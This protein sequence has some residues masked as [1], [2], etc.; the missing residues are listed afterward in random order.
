VGSPRAA[1][2]VLKKKVHLLLVEDDVNVRNATRLLLKSEGYVVTVASSLA[3]ALER[4]R[5]MPRLDLL[6]TDYHLPNG[7]TGMQVI[8]SLRKIRDY[9]VGA[10]LITGDTSLAVHDLSVVPYVR[11]ASKPIKAEELMG[12]L[13]SLLS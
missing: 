11:I 12:M 2:D 10:V 7:E 13:Q 1:P 6:L 4:G 5:A 8:E 9:P 3:E